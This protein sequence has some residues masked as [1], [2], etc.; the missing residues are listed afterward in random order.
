MQP[1]M[2]SLLNN[3]TGVVHN[4]AP[5]NMY[6]SVAPSVAGSSQVPTG[7]IRNAVQ[8]DAKWLLW[9][10]FNNGQLAGLET[11]NREAQ[12]ADLSYATLRGL[13]GRPRGAYR[14]GPILDS[15]IGEYGTQ[16]GDMSFYYAPVPARTFVN[17]K[18][19]HQI[20]MAP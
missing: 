15:T 8:N 11:L 14:S 5:Q 20:G 9:Q 3:A 4:L 10:Q 17:Q 2:S 7:Y 1:F 12:D 18:S 16:V 19:I 6:D 13:L